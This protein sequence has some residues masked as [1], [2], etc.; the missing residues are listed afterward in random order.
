MLHNSELFG[1][2]RFDQKRHYF[3][4]PIVER[5]TKRRS[6]IN[7][8]DVQLSTHLNEHPYELQLTVRGG[9]VQRCIIELSNFIDISPIRQQQFT[10]L[11]ITVFRRVHQGI[12]LGD[13]LV[14]SFTSTP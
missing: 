2:A 8:R 12:M 14:G 11:H 4:L 10:D 6:V 1:G 7:A 5:M 9:D 13:V 3:L